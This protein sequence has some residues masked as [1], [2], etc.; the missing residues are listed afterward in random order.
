[1]TEDLDTPAAVQSAAQTA[2]AN[3]ATRSNPTE[4]GDA[5]LEARVDHGCAR[6]L[7]RNG[8]PSIVTNMVLSALVA[9]V[10]WVHDHETMAVG[11]FALSMVVNV[12]RVVVTL[13]F[14]AG[15]DAA[16]EKIQNWPRRYALSAGLSGC[17]WGSIGF[18]F[19]LP[20]QPNAAMFFIVIV[21]G[22]TAGSVSSS[23]P[24]FPALAK[25][26][27]PVLL[28]LSLA[29][30]LRQEP[31]FYVIAGTLVMY[32]LMLLYTGRNI[33]HTLRQSLEARF[34]QES[35][36]DDLVRARDEANVAN[37]AKSEFL[38]SMSHE[39]RT[40]LN[41]I[42]GMVHLLRETDLDDGQR[43]RLTNV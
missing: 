18:L 11:W 29:L 13:G 8:I 42:L 33:N 22:I 34:R 26:L 17:V 23:S 6:I 24:H 37:R 27:I 25:F 39:I 32:L 35:L 40:P 9:V 20:D 2:G 21:A 10:A 14:D 12:V 36:V 1:M 4:P 7:R 30:A 5:E 19:I 3:G 41:G 15:G 31:L 16:S 43:G 38:S 28:P